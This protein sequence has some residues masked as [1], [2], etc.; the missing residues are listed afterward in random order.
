M[1][2]EENTKDLQHFLKTCHAKYQITV[3]NYNIK[4]IALFQAGLEKEIARIYPGESRGQNKKINLA[5]S[6]IN[7]INKVP[8]ENM[9]VI[10]NVV[11]NM[12]NHCTA[13]VTPNYWHGGTNHEIYYFY[14]PDDKV[15]IYFLANLHSK[16]MLGANIS[17]LQQAKLLFYIDDIKQNL[18]MSKDFDQICVNLLTDENLVNRKSLHHKNDLMSNVIFGKIASMYNS[19]LFYNK[20]C[21]IHNRSDFLSNLEILK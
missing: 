21:I 2:V 8:E 19:V 12:H 4:T 3:N 6:F 13:F 9:A 7:F 10:F 14:S 20:K 17:I 1:L 15:T 16:K 5:R 11:S 18:Y